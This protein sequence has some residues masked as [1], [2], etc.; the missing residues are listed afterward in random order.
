[1][2]RH[3]VRLVGPGLRGAGARP[4]RVSDPRLVLLLKAGVPL[5]VL[6]RSYTVLVAL[7]PRRD[8]LQ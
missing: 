3:L 5:E 6:Q 1:M 8:A 7:N 2:A 4:A